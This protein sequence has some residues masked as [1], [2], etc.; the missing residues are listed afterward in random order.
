MI[1]VFLKTFVCFLKQE[2]ILAMK[3]HC[4]SSF[5]ELPCA[6]FQKNFGAL[7]YKTIEND[8]VIGLDFESETYFPGLWT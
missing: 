4:Y 2:Y 8:L 1:W 6:E 7:A 5:L 3:E